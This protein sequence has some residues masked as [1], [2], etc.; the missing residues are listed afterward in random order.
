MLIDNVAL[1]T[2]F[3]Q[4]KKKKKKKKTK[5]EIWKIMVKKSMVNQLSWV[6]T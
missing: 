3:Y 6:Q 4:K 2:G 5:C 1:P